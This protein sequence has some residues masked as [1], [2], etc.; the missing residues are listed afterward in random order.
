MMDNS[1]ADSIRFHSPPLDIHTRR[2]VTRQL[3][4]PTSYSRLSTHTP[5]HPHLFAGGEST[6]L[7]SQEVRWE[8]CRWKVEENPAQTA[9]HG[10]T[11]QR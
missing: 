9:L 1:I 2:R 10:S 11:L 8:R 3:Y 4:A 6:A 5:L 7:E